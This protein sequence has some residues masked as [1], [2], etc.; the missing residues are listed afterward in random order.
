[1][2]GAHVTRVEPAASRD[3]GGGI[4][5]LPVAVIGESDLE[6]LLTFLHMLETGP[7]LVNVDELK[8]E[9]ANG[10]APVAA[11]AAYAATP[12][13]TPSGAPGGQP[14]VISFRFTATGFTLAQPARR[15]DASESDAGAEETAEDAE[16]DAG[17]ETETDAER[18]D[19][20]RTEGEG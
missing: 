7:K 4:T 18:S 13:Y 20:A 16:T 15:G 12:F 6:G 9:S 10:G 11:G 8:I 17:S 14:E 19:G 1:M 3:A 5:A 2:G